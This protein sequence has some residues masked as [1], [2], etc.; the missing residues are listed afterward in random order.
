MNPSR[1]FLLLLFIVFSGYAVALLVI[2]PQRFGGPAMV[3]SGFA[4]IFLAASIQIPRKKTFQKLLTNLSG[5]NP[6]N[7][8][9]S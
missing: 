6:E 9:K 5:K 3:L 4:G 1:T 7:P 8:Q 2:A